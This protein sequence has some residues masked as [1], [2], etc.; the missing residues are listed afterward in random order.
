MA[1]A[2]AK[3]EERIAEQRAAENKFKAILEKKEANKNE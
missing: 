2:K 3:Q 1:K